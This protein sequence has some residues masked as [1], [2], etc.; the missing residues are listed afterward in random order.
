MQYFVDVSKHEKSQKVIIHEIGQRVIP[1]V[2][3]C[4]TVECQEVA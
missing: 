4:I 1:V 2:V 3:H